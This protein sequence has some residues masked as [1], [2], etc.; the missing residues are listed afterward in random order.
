MRGSLSLVVSAE[1]DTFVD[2]AAASSEAAQ[3]EDPPP[4]RKE[5]RDIST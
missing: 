4:A 2:R 5:E 3:R 1:F